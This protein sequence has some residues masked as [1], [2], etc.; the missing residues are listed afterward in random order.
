MTRRGVLQA[1]VSGTLTVGLGG[2]ALATLL[3][4]VVINTTTSDRPG[5]YWRHPLAPT[6]AVRPGERVIFVPPRWVQEEVR[7]VAPQ[8]HAARPWMKRIA[9]VAGDTVCIAA[10]HVTINGVWRAARPLLQDDVLTAPQGCETLAEGTY[11]VLNPH[12]RS[13]DSRY[14][15]ALPRAAMQ[16]TAIPLYTWEAPQ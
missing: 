11:F 9:A 12:P 8:V 3:R 10:D 1:V 7:R 16:A 4:H 6:R 14:I 5:L 2:L 13:F 15:G